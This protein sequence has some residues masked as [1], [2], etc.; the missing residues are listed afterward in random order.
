MA[1]V[2]VLVGLPGA[3]KTTYAKTMLKNTVILGTDMIR[4]EYY[5]KEMTPRGYVRVRRELVRRV[6]KATAAGRD[7]AVDCTN[8]TK[9]RR[10]RLLLALPEGCRVIAV[11][12]KTPLIQALK[13]NAARSRHVPVPGILFLNLL[14]QEPDASEGFYEVMV[15]QQAGS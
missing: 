3:G 5:G 9:K 15:I 12:I 13:N 6:A 2:Y 7:V 14:L 4:K 10:R 11:W 1:T 8:L